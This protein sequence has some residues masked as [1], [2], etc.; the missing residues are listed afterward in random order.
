MTLAYAQT[1][2]PEFDLALGLAGMGGIEPEVCGM[3][4]AEIKPYDI[5]NGPGVRV[6]LFVS[7]CRR[8][9]LHC[10]NSLVWEFDCGRP[11][12]AETERQLLSMIDAGFINGFSVLGGEPFEPENQ[13]AL[14][15]FLPKVKKNVWAWTGFQIEE[16][17]LDNP[18]LRFVDVLVDGPFIEAEKDLGLVFRGSRNQRI[19]DVKQT[20][21]TGKVTLK[22]GYERGRNFPTN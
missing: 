2:D 16:L 22:R 7:G 17:G 21:E 14:L 11:F 15:N 1:L 8:H 18:L 13:T 19:I 9:C 6:S 20:L 10:F 5:A 12:T 4:Y 3:N